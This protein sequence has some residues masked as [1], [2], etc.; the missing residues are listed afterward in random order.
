MIGSVFRFKMSKCVRAPY[1]CQHSR[2]GQV[3]RHLG[4]PVESILTFNTLLPHILIASLWGTTDSVKP[5][6]TRLFLE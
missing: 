2:S 3:V 6:S 4:Q 5:L 1:D